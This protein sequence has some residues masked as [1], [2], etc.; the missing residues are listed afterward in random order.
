[1]DDDDEAAGGATT[2]PAA[3]APGTPAPGTTA[4]SGSAG[5][6]EHEAGPLRVYNYP[7]YVNP[8][9]VAAFEAKYGVKVEITTFDVDSEAITKL[10]SGAVEVDLH[11]SAAP[12][13]LNRL[14]EGGLLQPLDMSLIPNFATNVLDAFHDPW[15][16]PGSKHTVPY[17]VFSSGI[18]YRAD[19]IDPALVEAAGWDIL[20]DSTYK[21][22]TSIL[23]DYRESLAMAMLR[24]GITDVNTTDE[25]IIR[26]AG[27]DL[28]ELTD[29]V[30]IKVNIEAYK[31]VP[32][33]ATDLAHTWSGDM[34]A[35]AYSYLPE[36][37]DASVLGWWYPRDGVGVVNNDC[38]AITANAKNPILA[39]LYIDFL[40]DATNA[41]TNFTWNGYLPPIKGLDAD[42]L[43]AQGQVPENLRSAVL[44][45][46]IIAKG[47]RF[48]PLPLEADL[49]WEEE[50]SRFTAG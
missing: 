32:E 39:H 20:W 35:G 41:E 46:D 7:D 24:R 43:I 12:N 36:D 27:A 16:D 37:T 17:T 23:D 50:W 9:V 11:H 40:L 14:I 48:E 6:A 33:G 3:S 13:T 28:R 44:T 15:Y 4:G 22:V 42:Y 45:E 1:D 19:R 38:M 29:L 18:G 34:L 8:D 21:G 10:A 5:G 31:D 49:I 47:L 25:A 2:A 30:N 26:Q